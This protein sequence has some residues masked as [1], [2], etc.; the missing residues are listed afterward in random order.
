MHLFWKLMASSFK[1]HII[2]HMRMGPKNKEIVKLQVLSHVQGKVLV[3]VHTQVN[4]N[5]QHSLSGAQKKG[6]GETTI[7]NRAQLIFPKM[8]KIDYFSRYEIMGIVYR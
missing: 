3:N 8:P 6:P 2:L 7:I 1:D 5:I 4:R